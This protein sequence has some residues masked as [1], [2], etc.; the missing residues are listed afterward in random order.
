MSLSSHI[1]CVATICHKPLGDKGEDALAYCFTRPDVHAQAVFD[2][3]GGAGAWKY[4]EFYQATGAFVAAQTAA[5]HFVSWF[6]QL[7]PAALQSASSLADGYHDSIEGTL[8]QLKSSC[9]PMG[10]SGSW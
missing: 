4:P 8:K 9:E 10:V 3:C 6:D 2:G 5:E 7:Q 1:S